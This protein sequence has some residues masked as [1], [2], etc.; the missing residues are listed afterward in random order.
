ML[1]LA[2]I[3]NSDAV[4]RYGLKFPAELL[5][6]AIDAHWRAGMPSLVSHDAHRL[7][8]WTLPTHVS[9]EPGLTRL[10]GVTLIPEGDAEHAALDARYQTH[11]AERVKIETQPHIGALRAAI[12]D[13]LDGS[14]KPHAC[15][16]TALIGDGLARRVAPQVFAAEDK[17]GLVDLRGL[18]AVQPGVYQFG[19][20]VLFAH[21]FMRRSLSR[22]NNLNG[23]LLAALSDAA[24][25][26]GATV[27]VRI[28]PDM[29]GLA[30]SVMRPLEFDYWYGPRFDDALN[31]IPT[32]VTRHEAGERERF[33][34][35]ISR[36]EFWWQSRDDQHILEAEEVRDR[37]T[38]AGETDHFGCRYV[39][40]IVEEKTGRIVHLDGAIRAYDE[41]ALIERLDKSIAEAGRDTQ[42]TK[43]WRADGDVPFSFWK[44]LVHSYFRDNPLV[45]EYLTGAAAPEDPIPVAAAPAMAPDTRPRVVQRLVPHSMGRESGVRIL[46]SLHPVE[47][48]GQPRLVEALEVVVLGEESTTVL[49]ADV[50]ELRKILRRAGETLEL[51]SEATRLAFEDRYTTFPLIRHKDRALVRG[52]VAALRTLLNAWAAR[53]NDD[54]VIAFSARAPVID[55]DLQCAMI[56]HASRVCEQLGLVEELFDCVDEEARARWVQRAVTALEGNA[57]TSPFGVADAQITPFATF[58]MTRSQIDPSCVV[59]TDQG[60]S[61]RL[62]LDD[63]DL[64]SAVQGGSLKVAFAWLIERCTCS[65]CGGDY[66][67][68]NCSK[69][70]DVAV[71]QKVDEGHIAYAFWTDRHA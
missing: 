60:I 69:Y 25:L 4:N 55:A 1:E 40:S 14:E 28:D 46:L 36:T 71:T 5:Q 64:V 30:A 18:K 50:L 48:I 42:Y 45:T 61:L 19:D 33:F 27:R 16:A 51:P 11:L 10:H 32:G 20:V 62:P 56:G 31:S 65:G 26:K 12:S 8:G 2:V 44:R 22:W 3:L 41:E 43:L 37:P 38:V 54:R 23:D 17:D 21:P 24:A 63:S 6:R 35:G 67:A 70:L 68:C 58:R 7:A 66:A 53:T 29:V 59:P 47:A 9:V 13:H 34:F 49:D 39:H 15:A 52:T 57:A